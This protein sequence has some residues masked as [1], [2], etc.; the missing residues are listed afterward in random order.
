[1]WKITIDSGSC[2]RLIE[3]D[4][5]RNRCGLQGEWSK[6]KPC[7]A[8]TCPLRAADL[9]HRKSEGGEMREIKFRVWD[10]EPKRLF[11]LQGVHDTLYFSGG[12]A[13]Y[14]NLQNGSGGDEY[15]LMQFTGLTDKNGKEI[16][17]GDIL[18]VSIPHSVTG[19]AVISWRDNGF[20]LVDEKGGHYLPC[21]EYMEVAG[22][23]Y[24]GKP[25]EEEG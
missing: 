2:P 7:A 14:Y 8:A 22:N 16:Y 12:A 21:R 24:E 19:K 1:M 17:E 15:V 6:E 10:K 23:I 5:G 4:K 3:P 9:R 18:S 11:L 20:W 25:R 13:R